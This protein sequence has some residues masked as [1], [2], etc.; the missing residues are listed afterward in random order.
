MGPMGPS[1]PLGLIKGT[2]ANN[3]RNAILLLVSPT[4]LKVA[5]NNEMHYHENIFTLANL[6]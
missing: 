2:S 5:A 4:G 6:F 1:G 3:N